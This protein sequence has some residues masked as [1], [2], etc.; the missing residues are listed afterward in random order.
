MIFGC[1]AMR[2]PACMKKLLSLL[3]LLALAGNSFSAFAESKPAAKPMPGADIAQTASLITGVAVSPLIGV[4]AVGAWK[5]FKADTAEEKARLPWFSN[6]LFWIPC[7]LLAAACLVKDTA[8][9]ALPTV[10]KKPLDVAE[11][12]EHKISGL[13]AAGAFVP[14][15]AAIVRS[16]GIGDGA[17]LCVLGYAGIDLSWFY[18]ALMIPISLAA[19]VIVFLASNAINILI[20][21]SP[22]TTVDAALKAFRGAVLAS[23]VG[24]SWAN[25]WMGLAWALIIIL[26]SWLIAG[27]SFRL[28][29]FGMVFIWDIITVRRHRFKPH[30]TE[31]KMFLSRKI[32]KVPARTYGR[33]T[34]DEQGNL[35]LKYR[36]WLV[37]AERSVTLPAAKYAIGKAVFYSDIHQV[38]GE[39]T[40]TALMLPPRYRGHEDELVKIYNLE[41]VHPAGLR[42]AWQWIKGLFGGETKLAVAT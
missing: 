21:L 27:W 20:L 41:G 8:G 2:Q 42:A 9:T 7:F 19:F 37:L 36:P 35:T 32:E 6:P 15:A 31:N 29:H 23:I 25:P 4:S 26:I 13:V 18:N 24:T 28:W 17:S 34:R 22:F 14:I 12:I 30:P 11:A 3:L 16:S 1:I 10:A 33:L 39:K 5:Y 38:E 40:R